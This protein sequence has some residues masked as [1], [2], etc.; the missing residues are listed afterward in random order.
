MPESL[1]PEMSQNE[2]DGIGLR[3]RPPVDL[4]RRHIAKILLE[5]TPGVLIQLD[6]STQRQSLNP[7]SHCTT[8]LDGSL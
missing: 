3:K 6:I 1:D 2:V 4:F 5:G 8:M 7:A